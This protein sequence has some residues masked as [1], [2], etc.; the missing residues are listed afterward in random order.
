MMLNKAEFGV[1]MHRVKEE[2]VKRYLSQSALA[3][4]AGVSQVTISFIECGY[5]DPQPVTKQ[6]IADALELTVDDLFPEDE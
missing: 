4:K 3:K 1:E 5:T 2:R 6:K